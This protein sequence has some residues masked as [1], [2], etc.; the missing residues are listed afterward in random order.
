MNWIKCSDQMPPSDKGMD[1]RVITWNGHDVR[2]NIWSWSMLM[3]RWD[4]GTPS[5]CPTH[6]MPFPDPPPMPPTQQPE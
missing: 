1:L 6:W 4:W 5:P 3:H 2:E